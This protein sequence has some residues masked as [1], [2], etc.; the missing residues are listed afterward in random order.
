MISSNAA[1]R[2]VELF[3]TA[4]IPE[5]VDREM[6]NSKDVEYQERSNKTIVTF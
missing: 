5:K 1:G 6:M 3:E 4:R 2:I